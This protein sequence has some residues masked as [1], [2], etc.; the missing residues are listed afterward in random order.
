MPFTL[1]PA[2]RNRAA[3]ARATKASNSVYSLRSWPDSSQPKVELICA[4]VLVFFMLSILLDLNQSTCYWTVV[5]VL[6]S[7]RRPLQGSSPS[8]GQSRVLKV[9]KRELSQSSL[10]TRGTVFGRTASVLSG[11]YV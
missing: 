8:T 6:A 10:S 2:P 3:E 9:L 1:P 11:K 7:S 5:N 4:I